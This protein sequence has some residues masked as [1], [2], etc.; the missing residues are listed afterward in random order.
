MSGVQTG[1]RCMCLL[2]R[3]NSFAFSSTVHF[4]N[5]S[6]SSTLNRIVIHCHK[7]GLQMFVSKQVDCGGCFLESLV[8]TCGEIKP[9][10]LHVCL[11]SRVCDWW[12]RCA[13]EIHGIFVE[14]RKILSSQ[15]N[16]V[17]AG[18]LIVP[19]ARLLPHTSE[20][21][22]FVSP[23][24]QVHTCTG[25][26]V[27]EFRSPAD[28]PVIQGLCDT[29]IHVPSARFRVPEHIPIHWFLCTRCL[30]PIDAS[31]K[32]C[33]APCTTASERDERKQGQNSS[34]TVQNVFAS[35]SIWKDSQKQRAGLLHPLFR[36]TMALQ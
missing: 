13:T 24:A 2:L 7:P 31:S 11:R 18:P 29:Y 6:L 14:I 15:D 22:K 17:S 21:W 9:F 10:G 23:S 26:T 12:L 30:I 1:M 27:V 32:D 36:D 35:N 19:P 28:V 33:D 4:L 25:C 8:K 3:V 16:L 34:K 20:H 5:L